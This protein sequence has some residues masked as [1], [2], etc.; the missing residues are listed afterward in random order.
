MSLLSI[1]K[2]NASLHFSGLP[3][4]PSEASN[5]RQESIHWVNF[6]PLFYLFWSSS[7][8][9]EE[10]RDDSTVLFYVVFWL[11]VFTLYTLKQMSPCPSPP[12]LNIIPSDLVFW[13]I[14][15]KW[16]NFLFLFSCSELHPQSQEG[17]KM[18]HQQF[19]PCFVLF[20]CLFF[21]PWK[22]MRPFRSF[23]AMRIFLSHLVFCKW[24]S[25]ELIL[26]AFL[27]VLNYI[28][29]VR[30]QKIFLNYSFLSLVLFK[31]LHFLSCK[32][33]FFFLLPS[34]NLPAILVFSFLCFEACF[35]FKCNALMTL[36]YSILDFAFRFGYVHLFTQ[37][38][39]HLFSGKRPNCW[40][41]RF[42]FCLLSFSLPTSSYLFIDTPRINYTWRKFASTSSG[43]MRASLSWYKTLRS[44]IYLILFLLFLK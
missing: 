1:L 34:A 4:Y 20:K 15:V 10:R 25:N 44:I 29:E 21:L 19:L 39:S 27:L 22:Q 26:C 43:I 42:V 28:Q 3:E 24:L 23:P 37:H 33:V 16:V 32:R 38:I 2:G 31:R 12:V 35:L 13:Q 40:N 6:L 8:K 41:L 11:N 5:L 9:S 7:T 14:I 30:R 17:K 18:T 36:F